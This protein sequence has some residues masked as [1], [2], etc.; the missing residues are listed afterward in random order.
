MDKEIQ[1]YIPALVKC[2]VYRDILPGEAPVDVAS[3]FRDGCTIH[4]FIES[5]V[6]T[7]SCIIT[8]PTVRY[9]DLLFNCVKFQPLQ[10]KH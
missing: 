10:S 2:G 3:L 4:V 1:I 5:M 7:D 8:T 6:E 9:S